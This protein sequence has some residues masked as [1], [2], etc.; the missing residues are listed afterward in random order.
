MNIN[1][2]YLIVGY[3]SRQLGSGF[4]GPDRFN[5]YCQLINFKYYK[6]YLGIPE[7][8]QID[9]PISRIQYQLTQAVSDRIYPFIV[10]EFVIPKAISGYYPYPGDYVAFSSMRIRYTYASD[11]CGTS[12]FERRVEM[13]PDAELTSRLESTLIPPT[14]RRPVGS[15]TQLGYRIEPK[16]INTALLTYLRLPATPVRAYTVDDQYIPGN[17]T[18]FEFPQICLQDILMLLLDAAGISVQDGEVI[19]YAQKVMEKGI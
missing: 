11:E 5:E 1:D 14:V 15:W 19:A 10:P 6:K 7:E 12:A 3:F 8:W 9:N 17:S 4:V 2:L 13:I 18:Q 16:E